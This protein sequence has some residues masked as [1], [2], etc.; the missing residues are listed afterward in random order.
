MYNIL[1]TGGLGY[2]GSHTIV[3]L[4]KNENNINENNKTENNKTKNCQTANNKSENYNLI[5]IDNLSNS[6]SDIINNIEKLISP[7]KLIFFRGDI[8]NTQLLIHIFTT[9]NIDAVIH[10][11]SLKSVGQSVDNPLLYHYNNVGGTINL[12]TVMENFNVRNLIFSS[13]ATVYGAQQS[14]F[15]KDYVSGCGGLYPPF[16]EDLSTGNDITN[17]YGKTKFIIEE[18]LKDLKNWNIIIL[19]YFNPIGAHESG[20]I[21]ENPIGIPNNL[22]PYILNVGKYNKTNANYDHLKVFG[23][24]YDTVDGTCIRDYIHVVDLA[25][26]HVKSLEKLLHNDLI[27][28]NIYN[29][30]SGKGTSVLELINTFQ[31][32]NNVEIPYKIYPKRQGDI[33]Q[34]YC[35]ADKAYKELNW[36]TEKTIE[37]MCKDS[38]NFINTK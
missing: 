6:S 34:S 8:L 19:R 33:S 11:A 20:L 28:I 29:L 21:G 18:M 5:V 26:A 32:V 14:P 37:D 27:N 1:I 7:N 4:N 23:N 3:E 9:Y 17:P 2:I 30:G 13:S 35:V 36:K 24:D 10:F 12:L 22:M 15:T 31:L 16:T 38:W 25:K